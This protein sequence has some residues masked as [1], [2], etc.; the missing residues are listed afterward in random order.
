MTMDKKT[1]P[2]RSGYT[3][4]S[5]AAGAAKAA[6]AAL[7]TGMFPPSVTIRTPKGTALT[8]PV[9]D[10]HFEGD[11]AVCAVQKDSGDDPDITNGIFVYAAVRK[12]P[13]GVHIAGGRGVGRVTKP[14][15]NR[16]VGEAAINDGPRHMIHTAIDEI[17][18]EFHAACG[19]DITLSIPDGEKLAQ[20][21]FNPRL[22]IVGGLSIIGTTGIVEPMSHQALLDTTKAELSVLKASGAS[23]VLLSPGNYGEDF[24][25]H[26]LRLD[27]S[28]QV[29]TSNFIGDAIQEACRLQLSDILLVGHVGKLV[30]LTL[31]V[32]NTHSMYGDGRM[33]ALAACAIE[34]D[35]PLPVLRQLLACA[36]TD[37]ALLLL[38]QHGVLK[39]AMR[40]MQRR[41]QTTLDR[42]A[43]GR[44]RI[45]FLCFT[46]QKDLPPILAQ[47][48]GADRLLAYFSAKP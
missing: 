1:G 34:A 6:A 47:S 22:G 26:V 42:W 28:R 10:G 41:I 46:N 44:A 24:C 7:F 33:E 4:G 5:C 38:D 45:A 8:L 23:A 19:F 48:D 43:D 30:K 12:A 40:S 39:A 36:T 11:S 14:G 13:H 21:T 25:R 3:T 16:P 27:I 2:L 37:A 32:P 31:G 20:K 17:L 9:C 29:L 35:A 18:S 15:L